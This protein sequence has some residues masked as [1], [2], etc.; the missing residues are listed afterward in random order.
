MFRFSIRD[1]FWLTVVCA[2]G[3]YAYVSH[4]TMERRVA[5][6]EGERANE[7]EEY[8]TSM[9][10]LERDQ[11]FLNNMTRLDQETRI[12]IDKAWNLHLSLSFPFSN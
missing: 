10:K 7:R 1:L 12:L 5:R 11:A 6:M 8:A 2:L 9:A 4:R 3:S